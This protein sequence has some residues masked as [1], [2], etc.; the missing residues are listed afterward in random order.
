M[1][2]IQGAERIQAAID[3]PLRYLQNSPIKRI[4]LRAALA[5]EAG[6]P[7]WSDAVALAIEVTRTEARRMA[8]L[9]ALRAREDELKAATSHRG[10]SASATVSP[11]LGGTSVLDVI[12][13]D[14]SHLVHV[15]TVNLDRMNSRD[16]AIALHPV[17]VV[18]STHN[19]D[20]FWGP[21]A[22]HDGQDM[23]LVV[24][25]GG[26]Y[27]IAPEGEKGPRSGRGFGG[28]A[29]RVNFHDGRV[30]HTTNLWHGGQIPPYWR[31][32]GLADN[33]TLTRE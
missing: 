4:L 15:I 11:D 32:H 29:F 6:D 30:I 24:A 27:R 12:K 14:G 16:D 23:E 8:I 19:G 13:L 9:K 7:N 31:E 2:K 22:G 25:E 21:R 26:Y 1:D 28:A 17:K 20:D 10:T 33:A 3:G 5:G 18:T